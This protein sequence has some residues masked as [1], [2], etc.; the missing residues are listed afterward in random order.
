[1]GIDQV[2]GGASQEKKEVT[3]QGEHTN[4]EGYLYEH[5]RACA[6]PLR[7]TYNAIQ[8]LSVPGIEPGTGI[9]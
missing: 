1:M 6:A 9:L 5:P 4:P 2:S 8:R 3:R 7:N